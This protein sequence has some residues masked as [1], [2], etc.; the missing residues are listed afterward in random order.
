MQTKYFYVLCIALMILLG[1][2]TPPTKVFKSTMQRDYDDNIYWLEFHCFKDNT[3]ECVKMTQG[4]DS[5]IIYTGTYEGNVYKDT[6]EQNR[7]TFKITAY[8]SIG[9]KKVVS[10]P[11]FLQR[12]DEVTIKKGELDW[13]TVLSSVGTH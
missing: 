2:C 5:T 1:S 4:R 8:Y 12:V 6:S 11:P 13:E 7:V 9:D 3:W 10:L